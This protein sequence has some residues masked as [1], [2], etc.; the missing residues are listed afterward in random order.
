MKDLPQAVKLNTEHKN[1]IAE[2]QISTSHMMFAPVFTTKTAFMYKPTVFSNVCVF[3][4][5][6]AS[7]H[8]M[9]VYLWMYCM[10]VALL[11]YVILR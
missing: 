2:I 3:V 7:M 11:M 6:Q 1:C 8:C 4:L 10:Y 9:H 5:V